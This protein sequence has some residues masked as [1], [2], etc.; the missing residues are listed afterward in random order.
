MRG[1]K[2]FCVDS[3]GLFGALIPGAG[4]EA[5][6]TGGAMDEGDKTGGLCPPGSLHKPSFLLTAGAVSTPLI[7]DMFNLVRQLENYLESHR[8]VKEIEKQCK[9]DVTSLMTSIR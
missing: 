4:T 3:V 5:E 8:N 7:Q 2:W 6:G 9:V 1:V